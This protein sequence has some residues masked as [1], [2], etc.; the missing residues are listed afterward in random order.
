[1][2]TASELECSDL[3]QE[4]CLTVSYAWKACFSDIDFRAGMDIPGLSNPVRQKVS[5]SNSNRHCEEWQVLQASQLGHTALQN[6]EQASL[7][8][9]WG[10]YN[11]VI[12]CESHRLGGLKWVPSPCS[13]SPLELQ[14]FM[15]SFMDLAFSAIL[16]A[17]ETHPVSGLLWFYF[18]WPSW[19]DRLA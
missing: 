2:E 5:P 1:M 8:R 3:F 11:A 16:W 10:F 9:L 17:S 7:W 12:Q 14:H 19:P 13:F 18:Q 4:T 15:W 6:R